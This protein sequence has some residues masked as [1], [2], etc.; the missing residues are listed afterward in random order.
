MIMRI[1]TLGIFVIIIYSCYTKDNCHIEPFGKEQISKVRDSLG[2]ISSTQFK[3]YDLSRI[4]PLTF[5]RYLSSV[6]VFEELNELKVAGYEGK[7]MI[8]PFMLEPKIREGWVN[9][10]DKKELLKLI[11]SKQSAVPTMNRNAA[12]LPE[13]LSTV[14]IEAMHLLY[15]A[16]GG[17]SAYVSTRAFCPLEKQDSMIIEYLKKYN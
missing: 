3:R 9:E 17:E 8:I 1:S 15:Y 13:E 10:Y 4:A 16:E 7:I 11:C 14:G 6:E 2:I 12:S 5:I